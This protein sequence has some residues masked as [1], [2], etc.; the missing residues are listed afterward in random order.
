MAS[1][2]SDLK[3]QLMGT[4]DNSGTWGTI[5]NTNLGTALEEAICESAD[6][7]FSQDSLT[8]SLTDSNATQTARHLRLNLTGTGSAGITLTVPDIEKNYIINN[9]LATDVGI[10]NSSGSQVTVPNGRSA[11]VYSTGSGVVD[12]ITGL[13]TAEVTDLTVTTKLSAN[14]TLDVSGNGSVGGTFNVEGDLK[15]ASGN[16]TVDPATQIVE[17]K[18]NGSDTEGQIKLNCHANSHGQTIKAQPHSLS[19]TNTSLLPKGDDSTLVSESA[20]ATLTNKIFNASL[21]EKINVS[22]TSATGV[23]NFSV[24]EQNAELRTNDAAANFELNVRGSAAATF[25]SIMPTGES[26][27][28]AFESSQGGT[29]YY[30]EAIQIDGATANP[31]YW[32][33][34]T[35]PSQGNVSGVDSYLINITRTTGT[36]NYTCLASQTQF[37]KVDY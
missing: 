37:G 6:V 36:A 35:A 4:G 12:A 28:I 16:L 1:T 27:S 3:I 8:L 13:N 32:Q 10:K 5:T 9:T 21:R 26:V 15:N 20:S 30:L 7:A 31:V 24:L 22:T 17:I 25:A 33:G 19:I 29:A 34:G 2:Y 11:I 14:G 18:G 23:I